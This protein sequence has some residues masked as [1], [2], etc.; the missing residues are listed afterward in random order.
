MS[1]RSWLVASRGPG[2]K[3]RYVLWTGLLASLMG[4]VF[5]GLCIL[6]ALSLDIISGRLTHTSW[7]SYLLLCG[8][9]LQVLSGAASAIW[10][11][12]HRA[13]SDKL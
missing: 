10:F 5:A 11:Y 2:D 6:F 7:L 1:G 8:G 4:G 12:R 3:P 13:R 9:I